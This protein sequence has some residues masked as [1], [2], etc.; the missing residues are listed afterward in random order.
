MGD[1]RDQHHRLVPAGI[2]REPPAR[3]PPHSTYRRPLLGTGLCG[4]YTT[5]STTQAEILTML[6]HN[7]YRL[8]GA[9]AASSILAGLAATGSRNRAGTARADD[10]VS[11][12]VWIGVGLSG[13]IG[14][15]VR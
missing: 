9:Y 3:A 15:V 13:G 12:W 2:F 1:V 8:A 7:R 11:A 10:R 6:D 14:A 5:F 4:A